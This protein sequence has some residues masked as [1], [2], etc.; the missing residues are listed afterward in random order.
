MKK[1]FL[2]LFLFNSFCLFAQ[3]DDDSYWENSA[4]FKFLRLNVQANVL[5]KLTFIDS[6]GKEDFYLNNT[7]SVGLE[8]V[9]KYNE[10]LNFGIGFF[11]QLQA[12][13]DTSIGKIGIIPVYTYMD[14]PLITN[15]IFP[16]QFTAQFGYAFLSVSDGL[17]KINHG[18]YHAFGFTTVLS[19]YI[20]IKF[21]Y[22]HNYGKVKLDLDEYYLRKENLTLAL[23]YKF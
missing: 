14:F 2:F 11:N 12:T 3:S 16:I 1:L 15:E 17:K 6:F 9:S 21:L 18:I 5:Q 8:F 10:N 22:A 19:R 20:Q 13:I 23:Y 4:L 7:F